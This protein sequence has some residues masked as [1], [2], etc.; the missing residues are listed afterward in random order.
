MSNEQALDG[1]WRGGTPQT[2]LNNSNLFALVLIQI[3]DAVTGTL[4]PVACYY[5]TLP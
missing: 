1:I 4:V 2:I 3:F 5:K